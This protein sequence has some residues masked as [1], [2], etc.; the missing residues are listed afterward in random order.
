MA[1]SISVIG[2]T[3]GVGRDGSWTS[4]VGVGLLQAAARKAIRII[5]TAKR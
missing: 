2:G 1:S 5:A 3:S 4:A